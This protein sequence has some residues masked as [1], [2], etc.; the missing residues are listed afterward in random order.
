MMS[1]QVVLLTVTAL[2]EFSASRSA[3]LI[4]FSSAFTLYLW[5]LR[6]PYHGSATD[7]WSSSSSYHYKATESKYGVAFGYSLVM[8]KL[9]A[10][11]WWL[12]SPV[13]QYDDFVAHVQSNGNGMGSYASHN[14][15]PKN[16]QGVAFGFN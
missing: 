9:T 3:S 5:W 8:L 1:V 13:P 2:T 16:A 15:N 7:Y 11:T 14:G 6:S 10:T 12:R 4:R